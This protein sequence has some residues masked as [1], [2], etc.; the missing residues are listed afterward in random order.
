VVRMTFAVA[1]S[2]WAIL[3]V[4]FVALYVLGLGS[5]GLGGVE[6]FIASLGITGF[7]LN[8]AVFVLAFAATGVVASTVV[9]LVAGVLA[10]LFNAV[11][12]MAGGVVTYERERE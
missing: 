7:R 12:P 8:I 11:A 2:L 10:L 3:L 4:G 5:G 6:G 1:L 9:A